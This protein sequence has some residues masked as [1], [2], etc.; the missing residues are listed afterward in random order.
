MDRKCANVSV[1]RLRLVVLSIFIPNKYFGGWASDLRFSGCSSHGGFLL[2][3]KEQKR[4]GCD[5]LE[6][7]KRGGC[8]VLETDKRAGCD[9]LETDKRGGTV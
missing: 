3:S 9:V 1:G 8:D 6:T 4:G 5:V 2:T 7:D